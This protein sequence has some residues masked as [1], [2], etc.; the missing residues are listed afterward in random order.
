MMERLLP[1][2][3]ARRL[4]QVYHI[5]SERP[6]CTLASAVMGGGL[7]RVHHI[8]N[9]HVPAQYDH[10]DPLADWR[11]YAQRRGLTAPFVG[12]LTAAYVS[13]TQVVRL[14]HAGVQ[15]AVVGTVG[16]SNGVVAG[17]TP[18]ARL[19][20]AGTIN[21]IVLVH[22]R[23]MPAALVNVALIATEAKTA[24]LLEQ[25]WPTPHGPATG[26]STDAVVVACTGQGP[27]HMYAGPVTPV[28]WLVA[29]GVRQVLAQAQEVLP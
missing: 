29:R 22:A 12:L 15:V 5:R 19:R 3:V 26:T 9:R 7:R 13:R 4:P 17:R 16:L 2:V 1:G 10:P 25:G 8:L 23:L 21:L 11:A 27:V 14:A 28:G 20:P 24:T 6:L 18:P